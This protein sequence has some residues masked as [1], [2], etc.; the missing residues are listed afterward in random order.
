M[1]SL[2]TGVRIRGSIFTSMTKSM[3]I[4]EDKEKKDEIKTS[5]GEI[6]IKNF[7]EF[8]DFIRKIEYYFTFEFEHNFG[9]LTSNISIFGTGF[10]IKTE[11][12]LDKLI[13]TEVDLDKINK[14]L[15]GFDKYSNI[16]FQKK[17]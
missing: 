12:N 2:R 10:K 14:I 3:I 7:N 6:F 13:G 1:N 16:S 5:A 11:I 9:Y 15:N 17:F 8:N 4:S